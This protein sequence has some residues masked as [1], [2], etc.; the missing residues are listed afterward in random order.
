MKYD[1]I[2]GCEVHVQLLTSSKAFCSCENS[3]GGEANTRVCPV[4]MGLPGSLPVTNRQMVEGAVLAGLALNSDIAPLTK[5]DRKNYVYPDLPKGYQI[6]QFDMPIC[7]GGYLDV[8]TE[9]GTTRRIRIIRLHMEEDA[10]KNIHPEDGRAVS[11]V[12]YNRCGTPLLEIVSEPDI[13]SAEEASVYVQSIREIF[14]ALGISDCNME[15]GSLRCDANIN[16]WVYEGEKRYATPIAEIK[17]MNSFRSIRSA[18]EYE[19]KRQLREWKDQRL[20]LEDTGKTTR[21]FVEAKGITVLQRTKEEAS[22][23][24]YFPEP[25]LKPIAISREYVD[26]LRERVGELPADRRRRFV[27]AYGITEQDALNLSESVALCDYFEEAVVGYNDPKKIANLILSDVKKYLN[28]HA[29]T[30]GQLRVPADGL[31]EL[32]G[33]VDSGKISGKIA[34]EVFVEMAVSGKDAGRVI[35]EK[36][37]SQIADSGA[38]AAMVDEVISENPASVVDFRNGKEKAIGYLM[39]QIMKKTRGKANPQIA[40]EL[41]RSKLE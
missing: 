36:G 24:R 11:F 7:S 14:R 18:L 33:L 39:G 10:G 1:V 4:C 27:E 25:D 23:Y 37:L 15:E 32:V 29:L 40:M 22:D 28:Q 8:Q 12:D 20:L 26:V 41:L 35:E 9:G 17:N 13:R 21:G 31:R 38:I 3:F 34:K 16:L 5:F 30:I 6:S 19:E 2:I